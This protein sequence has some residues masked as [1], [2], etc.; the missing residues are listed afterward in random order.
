M[1]AARPAE[2]LRQEPRAGG[3]GG[4]GSATAPGCC[5]RPRGAPFEQHGR[6]RL[7]ASA[8]ERV[9]SRPQH[10][11]SRSRRRRVHTATR[12]SR[13]AR[14]GQ[15][16]GRWRAAVT[17]MK[18]ASARTRR[19]A[20]RGPG[21]A[22]S[23]I[24]ARSDWERG[25]SAARDYTQRGSPTLAAH[26]GRMRRGARSQTPTDCCLLAYHSCVPQRCDEGGRRLYSPVGHGR[27]S[28]M[29]C[30]ASVCVESPPHGPYTCG[31]KSWGQGV[32]G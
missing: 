12:T 14:R 32:K 2:P 5:A 27:P 6:P 30:I 28:S 13:A 16:E 24:L 23:R 11:G 17:A 19:T 15:R 21:R 18:W 3:A 29:S 25:K 22:G 9:A 10:T 26:R 8:G 31:V 7:L 20:G 1:H 4:A